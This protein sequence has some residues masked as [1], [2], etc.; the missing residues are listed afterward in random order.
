MSAL[1]PNGVTTVI[2]ERADQSVSTIYNT[3]HR[4][5]NGISNI[6]ILIGPE[7]GFTQEEFEIME[8]YSA[9]ETN[10]VKILFVNLGE[11]LLL[12][13]ETSAIVAVSHI[14]QCLS[15]RTPGCGIH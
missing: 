11:N 1:H 12:R 3:V 15:S 14:Q 5:Y 8:K 2:S 9:M 7:D 10:K 4:H 6:G 13:S